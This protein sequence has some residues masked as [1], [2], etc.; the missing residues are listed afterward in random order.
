MNIFFA[1]S[2]EGELKLIKWLKK[3]FISFIGLIFTVPIG[4]TTD[5]S[6]GNI[7][8]PVSPHNAA[9]QKVKASFSKGQLIDSLRKMNSRP[10]EVK[11]ICA[12]CYEMS[13]PSKEV[14]FQC[15]ICGKNQIYLRQ[16]DEGTLVEALPYIKRS[17]SMMPYKISIDATALCPVCGRGKGKA[18]IM[19]V[20][21]FNCGKEFSWEVKNRED[22][23]NLR[24]LYLRPPMNEIDGTELELRGKGKEEIREGARYIYEYVFCPQC[25]E[26]IKVIIQ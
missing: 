17:L 12:M 18:L 10:E 7:T 15:D 14:D 2:A 1:G 4:E 16:S 20:D 6:G 21:C 3:I 8:W 13:L 11:V 25:R 5:V 23:V 22:V 26:E 24:W 19:N 9:N